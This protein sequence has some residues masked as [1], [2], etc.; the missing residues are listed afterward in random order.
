[1]L[2]STATAPEHLVRSAVVSATGVLPIELGTHETT[3]SFELSHTTSSAG[4]AR[5]APERA[6][7]RVVS[8]LAGYRSQHLSRH[9]RGAA[10]A[11]GGDSTT[12]RRPARA[13]P[14]VL[15]W[16]LQAAIAVNADGTCSIALPDVSVCLRSYA[17]VGG[18]LA[19][20]VVHDAVFWREGVGRVEH[21]VLPLPSLFDYLTSA[22]ALADH[23]IISAV[24]AQ[25]DVPSEDVPPRAPVE[26]PLGGA[27]TSELA[28]PP[29]GPALESAA[30]AAESEG[31][32]HR[33]DDSARRRG[34]GARRLW[35]L[36]R[37]RLRA[38][39]KE[40]VALLSRSAA[41]CCRPR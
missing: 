33:D 11:A 1:M 16:A 35:R 26:V 24:A 20:L 5:A 3:D 30:L 22:E 40:H 32:D 9:Q 6:A 39:A 21:T 4:I 37:Q 14:R 28:A 12:R 10:A 19:Q 41:P 13:R 27:A 34:A 25:H 36:L 18:A 38:V 31:G 23:E 8:S 2:L 15:E 29:R 7:R 17:T